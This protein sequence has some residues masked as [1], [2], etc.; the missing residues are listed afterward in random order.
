MTGS[1][2]NTPSTSGMPTGPSQCPEAL[3][4]WRGQTMSIFVQQLDVPCLTKYLGALWQPRL[5]KQPGCNDYK[6]SIM[7][8]CQDRLNLTTKNLSKSFF[9]IYTFTLEMF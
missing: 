3:S 9:Y 6:N 1:S 4:P 8:A 7:L 5:D 2:N